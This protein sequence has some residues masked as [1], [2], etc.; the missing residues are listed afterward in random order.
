MSRRHSPTIGQRNAPV[1]VRIQALKAD[2]PFWGY[3]RIWA[4]LRFGE[5]LVINKK[6][7]LRLMREH[8]LL[9][10][11]NPRLK[12]T[13]TPMRSK[14]R[15]TA[16]HQWWGIDMTKV[17]VEPIGWVYLV[18]VLDWYT[19]KIVGHYTGL[20]AKTSHWL[21]ALDQAVQHQFPPG[22][23]D[24]GLHLMSDNGCQPTAVAF[25]KAAATLG[26]TQAFTS[27]NNPKGNADTERLMRTLKE[28]LLWL[29]EWTSPLELEQAIG[30]WIEWYNTRYLHSTLGYRTPC[31]VEQQYLLSHSTQFVAA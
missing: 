28:E 25:M 5:E 10:T 31:Q 12:A 1:L 30:A 17:M 26:I 11:G 8:G 7:V 14:P 6:R 2:H 9:V 27:Y 3:R 16:P 20:Q 21:I 13:R 19:K 29:R 15:P 24:Q 22:S 18:V 4:Q 23:R